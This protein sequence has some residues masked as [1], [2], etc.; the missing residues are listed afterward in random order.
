MFPSIWPLH[1]IN[2]ESIY[3]D[4][5]VYMVLLMSEIRHIIHRLGIPRPR[6]LNALCA[7]PGG[8]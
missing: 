4:Q 7:A 2:K 1:L 3:I 8:A 5:K 6:P